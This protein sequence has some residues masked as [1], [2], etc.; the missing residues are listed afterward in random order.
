MEPGC[1]SLAGEFLLTPIFANEEKLLP[2]NNYCEQL[3]A[4]QLTRWK[5]RLLANFYL[6]SF[7][8]HP[9]R[10]FRIFWNAL[11]GRETRKL[12]TYLVDLRKKLGIAVRNRFKRGKKSSES[13]ATA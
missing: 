8:F 9:T 2:E 5:Y 13:T 12:E 4:Q 11:R 3:T 7:A 1:F 10:P 6:T